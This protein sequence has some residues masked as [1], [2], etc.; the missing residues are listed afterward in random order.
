MK[1]KFEKYDAMLPL[2]EL[3]DSPYQT[4]KHNNE[5]IE[6]L[7]KIMATHGVHQ[8]I[9]VSKRTNTICFGHGRRDAAKLNGWTTFPVVYQDFET[10]DEEIACV[11]S[12]N[13]IASW[14]ELD[15]S[16]VNEFNINLGP[17]FD[18]DLWGIKDF[19][20]EPVTKYDEE[21]ED[22]VPEVKPDPIS[23]PGDLY[24][25]GNHRL[26]CGD[27]T[28]IQ[29]V[30]LLLDGK[31]ADLL[32]TDPPYNSN[33][34]GRHDA[35]YKG[36]AGT[37][38]E[39]E[40]WDKNFNVIPALENA[41]MVT[42]STANYFVFPGWYPF[43]SKVFPFFYNLGDEWAV[44]PFIWVKKFA[45]SNLRGTSTA[46]ATEPCIMAYRKG[47]DWNKKQ[48]TDNY[49]WK[50][51]SSNEGGRGNHPTSKP[52]A[53]IEHLVTFSN[54]N[55]LVLDLF[56]GSG[57]TLIA[58]EKTNRN[59]F[60]CEIDPHYIDVIVTRWCNYTKTDTVYR[61]GEKLQWSKEVS[62][63]EP[64]QLSTPTEKTDI[65]SV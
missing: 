55:S 11:T 33:L 62:G 22:D 31:R 18:V 43:W 44:K 37:L 14:A 63:G 28:N 41:L 10:D 24:T 46:S 49:D 3:K 61:N 58:C 4:N 54:P 2:A 30:E 40:E 32:L 9:H 38:K 39:T 59:C 17:D 25:L 42:K 47:H 34:D 6:R 36:T 29:H 60:M 19:V 65:V 16:K 51:F 45:M 15:L 26:L 12:D 35:V 7:A 21:K 20:I 57:S 23:K 8:P 56:G 52:I 13:A 53:L 64:G 27:A 1:I 50:A 48:G 5:Q